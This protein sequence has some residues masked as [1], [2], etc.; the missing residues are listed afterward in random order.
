MCIRDSSSSNSSSSRGNSSSGVVAIN[1]HGSP[2]GETLR[3]P[4]V[5]GTSVG[6]RDEQEITDENL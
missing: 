2:R 3:A 1:I 4:L 5:K 6:H